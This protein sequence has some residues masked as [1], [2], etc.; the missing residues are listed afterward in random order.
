MKILVIGGGGREHAIVWRLVQDST[1]TEIFCAPGNAG[2]E[3]LARNVPIAAD[4][5]QAL[6]DW[7]Q[8][9]RPEL[10][11]VGPE[12][13][14]CMGLTDRLEAAGLRVFGPSQA[15][16]QLEGS[17]RFA[18]EL[19]HE[20]NVPTARY[21][22]FTNVDEA[23]AA[24]ESFGLPV[25]IKADGLAAGKGVLIAENHTD[26]VA[27]I[28]EMLIDSRFG[29]AGSE[30]VIEEF[31]QGEE[32]SILAL[33]D[34][35]NAVLLPASQDHKRA[36]DGDMGP[37]TGGMGAYTPAP[38]VTEAV[39]CLIKERI[40]LP[41]VRAMRRRGTPYK[42]VLYAGLMI[43]GDKI[44]VLEFNVRFGDP[45]AQVVLPRIGGNLIPAMQAC[46]DGVLTDELVTIR[47]QAAATVV[48]CSEGYPGNYRKG[49]TIHGLDSADSPDDCF[50]FHAGTKSYDGAIVTAGGRVLAVTALGPDLRSA[51]DKA[52]QRAN[53]ITFDGAH[54]RRDIAHRAFSR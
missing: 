32:A 11:V 21:A 19:M 46:I 45:E 49:D 34:G 54:Y 27:A 36:Y 10:T 48:M 12:V 1:Q 5:I 20:A 6:L 22:S 39:M 26:A 38:L 8:R 14:L 28:R 2:T 9:E 24:L 13:P 33:V 50:V 47:K 23:V 15:A 31:L 52:Y 4:D 41:V 30:I 43:D 42:G 16:A 3:Q 25:V 53:L 29:R 35:D 17:K 44:S 7:A 37:N 18:K 40:I 51:V